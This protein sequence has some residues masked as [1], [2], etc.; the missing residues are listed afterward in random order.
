MNTS[1]EHLI[2]RVSDAAS[3]PMHLAGSGRDGGVR[4]LDA[5]RTLELALADGSDA[6]R[7]RVAEL[8]TL[9]ARR[10]AAQRGWDR[11]L[12]REAACDERPGL[13]RLA[14]PVLRVV[15]A[16]AGDRC[17]QLDKL[18]VRALRALSVRVRD[19]RSAAATRRAASPELVLHPSPARGSAWTGGELQ[20]AAAG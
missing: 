2:E 1:F 13:G 5:R 9:V 7:D 19:V 20:E 15:T 4:L 18:L 10:D 12:A 6:V 3:W 16:R 8:E 17:V 11:A 14:L